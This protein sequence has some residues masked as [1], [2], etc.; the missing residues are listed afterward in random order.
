MTRKP[1]RRR[2]TDRP[3]TLVGWALT[4]AKD[5][6]ALILLA[7]MGVAGYSHFATAGDVEQKFNAIQMQI[8]AA[9]RDARRERLL[10]SRDG[11]EDKLRELRHSRS[12]SAKENIPHYEARLQDINE[13]LRNLERNGK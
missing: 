8:T 9:S 2:K 11:V 7:S 5:L 6:V 1:P 3:K 12:Q 4:H 13:R 10:A